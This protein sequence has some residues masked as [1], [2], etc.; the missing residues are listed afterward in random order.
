MEWLRTVASFRG[1]RWRLLALRSCLAALFLTG[2][3]FWPIGYQYVEVPPSFDCHKATALT[4]KTICA[5]PLL[6]K[7]DA[8]FAVYYQDNLSAAVTFSATAIEK[9]LKDSE[10]AFI[11]ARNR[12]GRNKWC[13]ERQYLYQDGRIA[14]MA[15][16]PPRVTYPL[17]VRLMHY[18]GGYIKGWFEKPAGYG[19]AAPSRRLPQ[20]ERYDPL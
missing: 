13:I 9:E 10:H 4:E 1:F 17:Q 8:D 11:Q 12:C 15:G 20:A 14:D 6:E 2:A 16:E 19:V 18:V 7:V 3:W 5:D